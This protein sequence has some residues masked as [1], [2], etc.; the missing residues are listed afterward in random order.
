MTDTPDFLSRS[1]AQLLLLLFL[2][3]T[4]QLILE[5][6]S[7]GHVTC[8]DLIGYWSPLCSVWMSHQLFLQVDGPD[9]SIVSHGENEEEE[10]AQLSVAHL[11]H[12]LVV[13]DRLSPIREPIYQDVV[14]STKTQLLSPAEAL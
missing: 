7:S 12:P 11:P 8:P 10:E 14:I 13:E 4:Q 6:C 1:G 3:L 2:L 5:T 9:D